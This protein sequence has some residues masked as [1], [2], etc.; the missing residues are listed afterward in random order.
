MNFRRTERL[1][2]A[3]ADFRGLTFALEDALL[4]GRAEKPRVPLFLC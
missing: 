4:P 3:A 1:A 2:G